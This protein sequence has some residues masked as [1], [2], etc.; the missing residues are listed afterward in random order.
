MRTYGI[1]QQDCDWKAEAGLSASTEVL[2]IYTLTVDAEQELT[3]ISTYTKDQITEYVC[4]N[5]PHL[6]A[7]NE[8]D[9]PQTC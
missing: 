8:L 2:T 4:D 7:C 5:L 6:D 1:T 9:D 3:D